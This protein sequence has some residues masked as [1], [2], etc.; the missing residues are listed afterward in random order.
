[1]KDRTQGSTQ[2]VKLQALKHQMSGILALD[3][4][5][6]NQFYLYNIS[7]LSHC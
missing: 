7:L 3:A 2:L 4:L 6:S 1:M 5:A